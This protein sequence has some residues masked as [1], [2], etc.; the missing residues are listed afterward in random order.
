[1]AN[2]LRKFTILKNRKF[3][4]KVDYLCPIFNGNVV[5]KFSLIESS[6]RNSYAKLLIGMDKRHD[7]LAWTRTNISHTKND[8]GWTFCIASCVGH[9][10]CNNQDCK[11][12]NCIHCTSPMNKTKWDGFNT[13]LFHAR[14]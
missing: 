4:L 14:C 7:G 6:S 11:Y 9:L 5:F 2:S 3:V 13:T 10:G 1:M 8:M 12:S